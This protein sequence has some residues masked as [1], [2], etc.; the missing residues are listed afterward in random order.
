M[1]GLCI[2]PHAG[3][4]TGQPFGVSSVRSPRKRPLGRRPLAVKLR[5]RCA[6]RYAFNSIGDH[7]QAA[8]DILDT[9]ARKTPQQGRHASCTDADE[10]RLVGVLDFPRQD[11]VPSCVR[12]AARLAISATCIRLQP[13]PALLVRMPANFIYN[14][15]DLKTID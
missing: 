14:F 13:L 2:P 7:P 11:A 5:Q 12:F 10:F 15:L 3:Q 6:N 1:I 4:Q 8:R 9:E